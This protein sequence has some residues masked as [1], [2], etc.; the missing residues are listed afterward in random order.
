MKKLY[1]LPESKKLAG[2]CAGFGDYFDLDPVLFRLLFVISVLFG[3]LGILIYVLLWILVPE[4]PGADGT[5]V[6]PT[7]RLYLS[8]S[9]RKIA[10]VCGGLGEWLDIDP[11]FMRIAFI[12][13]ALM[14]GLGIVLYFL[15]WILV[16]RAPSAP[17]SA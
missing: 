6:R 5:P 16:P 1:R 15:L 17:A 13:L 8:S 2:I 11:V 14:G 12:L 7:R 10:G 9:D 4:K 3:G